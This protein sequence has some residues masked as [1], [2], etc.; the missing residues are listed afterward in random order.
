[1]AREALILQQRTDVVV[2]GQLDGGLLGACSE[3]S[4]ARGSEEEETARD[5]AQTR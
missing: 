5:R 1:M 3:P 2:V 4:Q